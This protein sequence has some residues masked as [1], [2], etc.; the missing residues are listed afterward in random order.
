MT[1]QLSLTLSPIQWSPL[2]Q[3]ATGFFTQGFQICKPS[4][5]CLAFRPDWRHHSAWDE[6]K[7]WKGEKI[8]AGM[9]ERKIR[10]PPMVSKVAQQAEHYALSNSKCCWQ[11]G[12]LLA[13]EGLSASLPQIQTSHTVDICNGTTE[14]TAALQSHGRPDRTAH[15]TQQITCMQFLQRMQHFYSPVFTLS[16]FSSPFFRGMLCERHD[17]TAGPGSEMWIHLTMQFKEIHILTKGA[18]TSTW[19]LLVILPCQKKPLKTLA[20]CNIFQSFMY[21]FAQ[22]IYLWIYFST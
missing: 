8:K 1:S 18:A 13:G 4:P 19:D 15:H 14:N 21:L 16:T 7:R 12:W 9:T 2:T 17:V 20:E 10:K 6:L 5:F 11:A 3:N 22:V